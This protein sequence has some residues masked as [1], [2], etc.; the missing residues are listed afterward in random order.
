M[1]GV[2]V[3]RAAAADA[4]RGQRIL[5]WVVATAGTQGVV[6]V[7][8]LVT[9]ILAAR[10]LGP[11]LKGIYNAVIMWP[12][13]FY[14]FTSMGLAA[15]FTSAY[16][17][18]PQEQRR[19]LFVLALLLGLF[20][21]LVGAG[22]CTL[23]APRLLAHLG[24]EVRRWVLIGSWVP[25]PTNITNVC[26]SLLAVEER[27]TWMNWV[28]AGRALTVACGL[29]VLALLGQLTPYTQ[30]T[31]VWSTAFLAS[32]P[33]MVLAVR[34]AA[35]FVPTRSGPGMGRVVLQLTGLGARFYSVTLASTFNA[36]LDQMLATIWLSAT[37]IGLYAVAS[38]GV[39]VVGAVSGAFARVFFP[40][41][42][43]DDAATVTRWT[44]TALRRGALLFLLVE[45]VLV[46]LA[47]P[48]LHLL[49]GSRYLAAWPAVLTLAPE[50]VLTACIAVLYSGCYALRELVIPAIGEGVG[51]VTGAVMLVLFIPRWGIAGAGAAGSLS[52]ALDLAA[53]L[54][55]WMRR[56]RVPVAALWPRRADLSALVALASRYLGPWLGR[57]RRWV[58]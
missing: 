15:A 39:S 53:V 36:Q 9:G 11:E 19:R 55:L 13:V 18:A 47:R 17:R 37:Q 35:R 51:A 33:V 50:A 20:W 7:L 12:T 2:S 43:A 52:Y 44:V 6:M 10:V 28:N 8:N 3:A 42:A 46:V 48:G 4:H 14:G 23:L 27:F 22:L 5:R 32:L 16:A 26:F 49:Y 24:P 21:G 45:A 34:T 54:W 1:G 38:A 31:L 56:H 58:A 57:G 25:V 30:L 40:M 41:A 29:G